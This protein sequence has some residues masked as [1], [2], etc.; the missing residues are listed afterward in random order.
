MTKKTKTILI[1]VGIAVL[2]GAGVAIGFMVSWK[3][4]GAV[5]GSGIAVAGAK[6]T[7]KKSGKTHAEQSAAE[8]AAV[9]DLQDRLNN[10]PTS[11]RAE[12]VDRLRERRD[13][14]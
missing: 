4:A 1:I 7:I 9:E 14:D 5:I 11:G 8:K 2:V 10:P 13:E 3:A 12:L 6:K